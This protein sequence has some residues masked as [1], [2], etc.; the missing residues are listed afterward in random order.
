MESI[1]HRL[2]RSEESGDWPAVVSDEACGICPAQRECP[3]P[4]ALRGV[5]EFLETPEEAAAAAEWL[6]VTRRVSA[7]VQKQIKAVAKK[8]GE[9]IR[10]G[11]DK[12]QSFSYQE[13]EKVDKD[14]LR[15]AVERFQRSGE[16]FAFDDFVKVS[17]STPF[18]VRTL[19]AEELEQENGS[20][21]EGAVAGAGEVSDGGRDGSG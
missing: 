8:T 15:A 4:S 1:L 18:R 21:R 20:D 13:T 2:A 11:L 3:I 12:E 17:K 16:P 19:T 5:L 10:F 14:G 6:E 9:P 7:G